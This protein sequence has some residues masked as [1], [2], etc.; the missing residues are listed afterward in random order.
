MLIHEN[1]YYGLIRSCFPENEVRPNIRHLMC[2]LKQRNF[3]TTNFDDLI[4]K[5]VVQHCLCY[6]FVACD[7]EIGEINGY[8]IQ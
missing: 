5:T 2:C 6:K 7:F 1:R 3:I 4:E 8:R